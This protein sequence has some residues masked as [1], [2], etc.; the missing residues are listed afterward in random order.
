MTDTA[1]ALP[2]GLFFKDRTRTAVPLTGVTIDAEIHSFYARVV[3]AQR[4]VNIEANPI[5]AVYLFPLDEG[6]AICGFEAVVD[7]TL[8]VGEIHEREKAFEIYDDAM[9]AGHGA[10][11]LDE[12]RADGSMRRMRSSSEPTTAPRRR[13]SWGSSTAERV[14]AV[15]IDATAAV[16]ESTWFG[17]LPGTGVQALS[18]DRSRG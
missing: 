13:G 2:T 1:T 15:G 9:Q 7:G 17:G 18:A 3:V 11:L 4:Y 10:F 12:E 6:A 8:V 14:D 5:E 16:D